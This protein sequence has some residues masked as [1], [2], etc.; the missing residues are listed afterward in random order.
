MFLGKKILIKNKTQ[1]NEIN[2]RKNWLINRAN[3]KDERTYIILRII[4][5][6][7]ENSC[8]NLFWKDITK[9]TSFKT[10]IHNLPELL[11]KRV[12]LRR[13]S[14]IDVYYEHEC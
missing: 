2:I 4:L 8:K 3:I 12:D 5:P 11:E 9:D 7:N 10:H 14:R 13:N 1:E 6:K